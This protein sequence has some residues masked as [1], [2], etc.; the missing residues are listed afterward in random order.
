MQDKKSPTS[1]L[2]SMLRYPLVFF[3][4]MHHC[5][6]P[7]FDWQYNNLSEQS[8]GSN[9]VS[10]LILSSRLLISSVVSIFY[11]ISGYLFFIHL[12][13]WDIKVW[14]RKMTRRIW[15]LLIPYI[16]WNTLYFLYKIEP[17]ITGCVINGNPWSDVT[18]WINQHGGWIGLYWNGRVLNPGEVDLWGQPNLNAVPILVPFYYIRNLIVVSLFTPLIYYL[19][20]PRNHRVTVCAVV[21]LVVLAFLFL[22]KTSFILSGFT[23]EAFLF[24]GLGAFMKLNGYEL[25]DFFYSKRWLAVIMTLFL[26]IV[27][28]YYGFYSSD[29]GKRIHP[30][31]NAFECMTVLNCSSWLVKKSLKNK[32]M[33]V[34]KN[35]LTRWQNTSFMLYAFHF[36][37]ITPVSDFLDK[38]GGYLTGF[39]SIRTIEMATQYPYLSLLFFG[40]R[41]VIIVFICMSISILLEKFLPRLNKLFC[42]R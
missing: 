6:Y 24:F 11:M 38:V 4:V 35:T 33:N 13:E 42:G 10:E 21:T 29:E 31:Y 7:L 16:L 36:F 15:S 8:I 23:A 39:Y 41:I 32:R 30:F 9:V 28:L 3:V 26:F 17:V 34:L 40:A 25:S 20:H 19:L 27:E 18:G 12:E 2:I 5:Y 1:E 37:L 22:T 14:K